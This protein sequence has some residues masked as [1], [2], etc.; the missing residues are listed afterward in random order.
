MQLY[1]SDVNCFLGTLSVCAFGSNASKHSAYVHK[2]TNGLNC[3]HKMICT[4]VHRSGCSGS[5]SSSIS[6]SSSSSSGSSCSRSE[7]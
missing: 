5:S 2:C 4:V 7:I 6:S 1:A 3:A